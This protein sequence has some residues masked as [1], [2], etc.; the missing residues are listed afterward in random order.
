LLPPTID[1]IIERGLE[2]VTLHQFK[3]F[4]DQQLAMN[5]NMTIITNQTTTLANNTA[6]EMVMTGDYFEQPIVATQIYTVIPESGRAITITYV[7]ETHEFGT[8]LPYYN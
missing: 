2:N 5:E 3:S 7:A 1:V 4:K 6:Y 8:Y